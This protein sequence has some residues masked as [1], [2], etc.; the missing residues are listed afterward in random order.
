MQRL[1]SDSNA[2]KLDFTKRK[3]IGKPSNT[4]RLNSTLQINSWVKQMCQ[5]KVKYTQTREKMKNK[6]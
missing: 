5:K 1:F 4:W 2:V 6:K 3:I